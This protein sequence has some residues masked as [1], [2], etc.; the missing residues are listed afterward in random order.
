VGEGVGGAGTEGTGDGSGRGTG[1]AVAD[2]FDIAAA[3]VGAMVL[4]GDDNGWL[5]TSGT[6]IIADTVAAMAVA[7][8]IASTVAAI[9]AALGS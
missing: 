9:R 5:T 1:D 4:T 8:T 3:S 7:S 2:G 6:V